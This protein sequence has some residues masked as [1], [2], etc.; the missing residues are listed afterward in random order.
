[1][2]SCTCQESFGSDSWCHVSLFHGVSSKR[3]LYLERLSRAMKIYITGSTCVVEAL[4][5]YLQYS[6]INTGVYF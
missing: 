1:M 4:N 5:L 3:L 2:D 6:D